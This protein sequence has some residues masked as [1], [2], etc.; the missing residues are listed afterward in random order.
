VGALA[1]DF[2]VGHTKYSQLFALLVEKIR[3]FL[4]LIVNGEDPPGL[5]SLGG[6]LV[7]ISG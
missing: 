5:K 7:V 1:V 2:P 6:F 3:W 4:S